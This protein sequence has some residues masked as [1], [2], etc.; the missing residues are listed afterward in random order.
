MRDVV[1]NSQNIIELQRFKHKS[2]YYEIW[3]LDDHTLR[4]RVVKNPPKNLSF[5]R[6]DIAPKIME[7]EPTA[8]IARAHTN[9]RTWIDD[10]VSGHRRILKAFKECTFKDVRIDNN[11]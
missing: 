1:S 2:M 9:C 10:Y 8:A 5:Y 6:G 4:Y 3:L 11:E 7:R